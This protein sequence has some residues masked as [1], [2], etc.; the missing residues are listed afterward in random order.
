MSQFLM[1]LIVGAGVVGIFFVA[2]VRDYVHW[3]R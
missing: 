3:R 1:G 2:Y